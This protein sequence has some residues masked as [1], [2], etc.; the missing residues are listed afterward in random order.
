MIKKLNKERLPIICIIILSFILN[1]WNIRIQG[2]GNE[3]YA[4]GIKSMLTSFKNF[5]F[6]SFDPSGFVSL[7]KV[8][9]GLWIQGIFAKIFG[10][11]GFSLILPGAI[12]GTICVFILYIL[13]K[14]YFGLMAA[15]ISSLILTITPIF[16]AVSRTN[17]FQ[18]IVVLFMMLS[19]M[20][21]IK[22]ARTGKLKYL[23]V[24]FVIIGISFNIN[25]LEAFIILPAIYLTYILSEP[26]GEKK[27]VERYV[28]GITFITEEKE[29]IS[30][31]S[32]I[33]SL[34]IATIVLLVVSLSWSFLVDIVP[35][36][37]RPYIGDSTTNSEIEL[38]L[39]HYDLSKFHDN[40]NINLDYKGDTT[41]SVHGLTLNSTELTENYNTWNSIHKNYESPL[42]IFRLF[43]NSNVTDQ[44]G[45]FLPLA[46]IGLI[47][48]IINK[49]KL[50][51]LNNIKNIVIAFFA[52]WFL[53]EFLCFSFMYTSIYDLATLAV[54]TAAL[55]GIGI[56]KM[57]YIY[58]NNKKVWISLALGLNIILQYVIVIYYRENLSYGLI[59]FFYL[60]LGV[61]I[62]SISILFK[63]RKKKFR[64]D[65]LKNG[66]IGIALTGI[67]IIPL[68]GSGASLFY[69]TDGVFKGAGL[70]LIESKAY[71]DVDSYMENYGQTFDGSEDITKLVGFLLKNKGK[72]QEYLLVTPSASVY[73]SKIILDTG[74]NVMALGGRTGND[75]IISLNAFKLLVKE[76]KIKYVLVGNQTESLNNAA[77]MNW[78][79]SVGTIIP[80]SDW[81][82]ENITVANNI[83][84]KVFKTD[85]R[86]TLYEVTPKDVSNI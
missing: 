41:L 45:W 56:K 57:I 46:I 6:L 84:Y 52:I 72:N 73:A 69:K 15:I 54:P 35:V 22:A 50:I 86:D 3:Y 75:N 7:N 80:N 51:L 1:I 79:E 85:K 78:V 20:P 83:L 25:R 63:L 64:N 82:D 38:A 70:Q 33:K 59:H 55:C 23:I 67:L 37:N 34:V 32:K 65:R 81:Q 39:N 58:K 10:F 74:D 77:I 48:C 60:D 40:L 28:Y 24:S 62:I 43:K 49:R 2:Y 29:K 71:K 16:V 5:F 18:T 66:L 11:S 30:L 17:D 44:I 19:I 47:V 68:I 36:N 53:T 76:G 12:A 4:A 42:G 14:R 26:L 27:V 9:L 8:P 31:N 21:A 61:S 13:I